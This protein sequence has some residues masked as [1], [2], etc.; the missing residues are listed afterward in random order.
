MATTNSTIE[1]IAPMFTE[2]LIKKIECLKT[3]WQK[4][5]ITSLEQGLPRNIHCQGGVDFNVFYGNLSIMFYS[6]F[7]APFRYGLQDHR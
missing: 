3:D 2:L 7:P 1:K 6:C 4:P 5:W